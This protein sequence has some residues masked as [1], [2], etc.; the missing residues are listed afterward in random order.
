MR[1]HQPFLPSNIHD[2]FDSSSPVLRYYQKYLSVAKHASKAA[3]IVI[4]SDDV[5]NKRWN[6]LGG[7]YEGFKVYLA[8]DANKPESEHNVMLVSRDVAKV[9][10]NDQVYNPLA[11]PDIDLEGYKT[12]ELDNVGIDLEVGFELEK[13]P[14]WNVIGMV[15]GNDPEMKD[16]YI[17][18]GGHLDHVPL[19]RGQVVNGADDNASGCA[20]VL[21]VA[22]AIAASPAKRSVIFCLW[23]GEEPL[24]GD[25]CMG[26]KFFL[27]N[28]PVPVEKMKAYINLDII[29]RTRPD[30]EKTRAHIIGSTEEML[31]HV[32]ALVRPINEQNVKWPIVYEVM[33][34]SDHMSFLAAGIP[35][36]IFFS[37]FH[38]DEHTPR[39]DPERIDYEKMEKLSRLAF[40]ITLEL[41]NG[42]KTLELTSNEP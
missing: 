7:K 11:S 32:E 16:E 30:N 27:E 36:F 20:G 26:S 6:T 37:G 18:V 29:G 13:F 10:F 1:N 38:G 8:K 25:H 12:Y 2:V 24:R 42:T 22:E 34:T 14:S 33:A 4:V 5:I 19:S 31:P 15:P 21:E 17:L 41:A 40:W 23:T 3:A 35:A 28:S 39:D 9:L